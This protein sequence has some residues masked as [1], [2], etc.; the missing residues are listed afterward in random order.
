M[1]LSDDVRVD[2]A[3]GHSELFFDPARPSLAE[4]SFFIFPIMQVIDV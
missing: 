1:K 4:I 2:V 3:P